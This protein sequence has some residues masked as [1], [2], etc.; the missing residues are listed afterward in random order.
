MTSAFATVRTPSPEALAAAVRV[1]KAGGLVGVPTETVYGLA[2]DAG[3]DDAVARLYAVKRRPR[4]NPLIVHVADAEAARALVAPDPRFDALTARFW[5]GPLTLVMRRAENAPVSALALAGLDT[6]A[7][8][9]PAHPTAQALLAAF[10][11][12]VAP[13]ANPSGRASP[14]TATDVARDF[15]DAADLVLDGGRTALGVESTVVDLTVDPPALLRPGAL[16]RAEIEAVI[17]PLAA[18][19]ESDAPKSPGRLARH[20]AP[21]RARLRLEATTPA[22]DE[23]FLGFGPGVYATLNLSPAGDLAQ[24]AANL[25]RYLRALDD[26]GYARIAVAPIPETGLGEALNDRLRR[27]A[28]REP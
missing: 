21:R 16:A 10:G 18:P 4:I 19:A 8:R 1:L 3:S 13:S 12:L 17:G 7:V 11:A 26:S 20:Y 28:A 24:A 9:A 14:T 25:F 2:A 6:I 27:A 23:A 5:P 15:G 22:R